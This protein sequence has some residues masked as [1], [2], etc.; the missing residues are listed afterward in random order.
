MNA[1]HTEPL[2]AGHLGEDAPRFL[3]GELCKQV[4][5]VE[6]APPWQFDVRA[7]M[8]NLA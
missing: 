8:R 2:D 4:T 3:D 5:H 7:F 6:S 1:K